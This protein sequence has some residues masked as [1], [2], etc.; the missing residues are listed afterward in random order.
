MYFKKLISITIIAMCLLIDSPASAQIDIPGVQVSIELNGVEVL[1]PF[2]HLANSTTYVDAEVYAKLVNAK[3]SYDTKSKK[4]LVNG[5]KMDTRLVEGVP[6]AAIR[7]LVDATGGHYT[8]EWE[9]ATRTVHI[10]DLPKGVELLNPNAD[11]MVELWAKPADLPMGPI[12]GVE[13]GKLVFLEYRV[14]QDFFIKGNSLN[15]LNGFK[16]IPSPAVDHVSFK[17]SEEGQPGL[18]KPHYDIHIFFVSA[19]V[20][21][22][23]KMIDVLAEK[24]TL[25]A[26]GDSIPFGYGL[27]EGNVSPSKKAYPHLIGGGMEYTADSELT[28]SGMKTSELLTALTTSE[29]QAALKQADVVTLTIGSNDIFG[30]YGP[31]QDIIKKV[32]AD[33]TYK[34]TTAELDFFSKAAAGFEINFPKIITEIRKYTDAKLVVYNIYNPFPT[35][36]APAL[37]NLNG[38]GEL[39]IPQMND[40]IKQ[41]VDQSGSNIIMADTYSAFE[42]KELSYVLLLKNDIHPSVTGQEA[43]AKL[44]ETALK[45]LEASD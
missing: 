7:P 27:E 2:N 6:T 34:T 33:A 37:T 29:Y 1:S 31:A 5:K 44:A 19:E 18:E 16:G 11:G 41:T 42:G 28:V 45:S 39:Y 15:S 24:K 40:K 26:L 4:A 22:Q 20:R 9:G 35:G 14:E 30:I 17:F 3:Y 23:L 25:V 36:F 10:L 12:F 8:I 13:Y 38:L 32:L 21:N 43:L